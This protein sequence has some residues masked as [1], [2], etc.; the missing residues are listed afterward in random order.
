MPAGESEESARRS[1]LDPLDP[2]FRVALSYALPDAEY[3]VPVRDRLEARG[4]RV[5]DLH[6]DRSSLAGKVVHEEVQQIYDS[7][8]YVLMFASEA[9]VRDDGDVRF[10]RR[11]ATSNAIRRDEYVVPIALD[12][13]RVPGLG[14]A[15]GSLLP[16]FDDGARMSPVELADSLFGFFGAR[17]RGT[18]FRWGARPS[19]ATFGWDAFDPGRIHFVVVSSEQ[20]DP[21]DELNR[22][23]KV[24]QGV[25]AGPHG[26]NLWAAARTVLDGQQTLGGVRVLPED[27]DYTAVQVASVSVADVFSSNDALDRAVR[28]I[29]QADVAVFDVTGFEPGVMLLLGIR[30]AA[31][32]GMTV[33]SHGG[34]WR[35]GDPLS[36]PFNLSDLSLASHACPD[37]RVGEE[38]RRETRFAKRL[39]TGFEQMRRQPHYHDLP[40]YD[41]L[42]QLGSEPGAWAPIPLGD[43]VLVLCTY[44]EDHFKAW[45]SLHN[46]IRQGLSRRQELRGAVIA[47]LQDIATPQVVSQALYEKIRRCVGC[48]VDWTHTSPSTFFE[49]GV[50]LTV[51]PW[52]TVQIIDKAW[53]DSRDPDS[54]PYRQLLGM[55]RAFTPLEYGLS[56][57]T[58]STQLAD[59][60]ERS[61][62]K[63]ST[64]GAAFGH[65]V[66]RV[67]VEALQTTQPMLSAVPD[68]LCTEADS[69]DNPV[70][71]R[72]NVPQTLFF[73]AKAIK[74]D[75]ER[76]A[77]ERRLA[78]WLYLEHRVQAGDFPRDEPRRRQW[79][80]LGMQVAESLLSNSGDDDFG[81]GIRISDL[82]LIRMAISPTFDET[83]RI[84]KFSRRK[85]DALGSRGRLVDASK[86]YE[87]GVNALDRELSAETSS[88][89]DAA[90]L[91]GMRGGLLRRMGRLDDALE[92]YTSGADIEVGDELATTYN[93]GNKIKLA[94]VVGRATLDELQADLIDLRSAIEQTISENERMA[95]D[96]W[97]YADLGDTLLLLG[98]VSRAID[99]YRTF[100]ERARTD[101]PTTTLSVLHEIREALESHG[102]PRAARLTADLLHIEAVLSAAS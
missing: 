71:E 28:I 101:S 62:V 20:E 15:L 37:D 88:P 42:R 67:V 78:A 58:A 95:S 30:G 11:E 9:Y 83:V 40:V 50:R 56:G 6:R 70:R 17:A 10:S 33:A 68:F 97:T 60:L 54:A 23:D 81:L 44:A 96:A 52:G 69:L 63:I 47:R 82:L 13:T 45:R 41:A 51:S 90:E 1:A 7:V 92:S 25:L 24:V 3:V 72:L 46:S 75:E 48:V 64:S 31:R 19:T 85:G 73:E 100:N 16:D 34:P 12:A 76:A 99:C 86:A 91:W 77:L 5:F 38:D 36:R 2:D 59:E 55:R 21:T 39:M 98:D 61:L 65:R 27:Y 22:L 49:L 80:R 14:G 53:W 79:I 32:R 74:A 18:E 57:G 4:V 35:E 26:E 102:D 87:A 43:E 94:L 89:V 66:R 84:A 8:A 29:V 93:R